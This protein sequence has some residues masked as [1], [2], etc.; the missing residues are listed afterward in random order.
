MTGNEES[1]QRETG[2]DIAGALVG[3]AR[4]SSRH[5]VILTLQLV[6]N[7]T[8]YRDHRF[9]KIAVALNERQLRSLARDLARAARARGISLN[10]KPPLRTRLWLF[11]RGLVTG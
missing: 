9:H 4:Q 2:A 10:A 8:D 1:E 11:L 3:W 5:G 7:A 6:H